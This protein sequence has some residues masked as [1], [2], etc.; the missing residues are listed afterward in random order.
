VPAGD[1]RNGVRPQIWDCYDDG[2]NQKWRFDSTHPGVTWRPVTSFGCLDIK[3]GHL[4]PG[5][6]V[7][8]W[9]C[10]GQNKNQI[11]EWVSQW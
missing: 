9:E 5:A 7:Q 2:A 8:F 6:E 1:S 11:M 10:N 3:D 4:Y